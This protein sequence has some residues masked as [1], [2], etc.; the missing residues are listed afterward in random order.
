MWAHF[1][2]RGGDGW[3]LVPASPIAEPR[4]GD[5]ER[6]TT[7]MLFGF[8]RRRPTEPLIGLLVGGGLLYTTG[9]VVY[10]QRWPDPA[11]R[12]FGFHEV[13]HTFVI[14]GSAAFL[15]AI[16]TWVLPFPRP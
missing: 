13:F 5:P 4:R 11:P 7:R 2:E 15:A 12:I 1:E 8:K 9:A 16:W 3:E 6:S 14:A 10:A